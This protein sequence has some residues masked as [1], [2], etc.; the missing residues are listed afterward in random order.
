MPSY[1]FEAAGGMVRSAGEGCQCPAFS[2]KTAPDAVASGSVFA[3]PANPI[4]AINNSVVP[5]RLTVPIPLRARPFLKCRIN[6]KIN[7]KRIGNFIIIRWDGCIY[8]LPVERVAAIAPRAAGITTAANWP[9]LKLTPPPIYAAMLG[10][11][12]MITAPS[13]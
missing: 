8:V 1:W 6:K 5:M 7:S 2:A 11:K 12:T 10:S 4:R 9:G 3:H 13:A